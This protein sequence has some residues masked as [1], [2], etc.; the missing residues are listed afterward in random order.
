MHTCAAV[1]QGGR[2]SP[3]WRNALSRGELL[4]SIA[5]QADQDACSSAT[6]Q[7]MLRT[8]RV[9]ALALASSLSAQA[10]FVATLDGA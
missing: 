10:Y 8:S 9:V 4:A 1:R 3:S 2:V 7:T 5:G 6:Q